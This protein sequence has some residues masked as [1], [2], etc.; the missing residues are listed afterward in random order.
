[1]IYQ[2]HKKVKAEPMNRLDYNNLRGWLLPS[3]ECGEDEGYLVE[4]MDGGKAN[5]PDFS[6]YISWSPKE[7]FEAGYTPVADA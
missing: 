4:Y 2:C 1:M 5:H 7:V 3:D 6:G